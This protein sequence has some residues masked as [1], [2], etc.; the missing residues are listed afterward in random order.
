MGGIG[1]RSTIPRVNRLGWCERVL[2]PRPAPAPPPLPEGSS[3]STLS[4]YLDCVAGKLDYGTQAAKALAHI[5][6]NHPLRRPTT[7]AVTKPRCV[8]PGIIYLVTRRCSERRFFLRPD[9]AVTWVFEYLLGLLSKKYGIAIHAYVVMSNHYH[10]VVTDTEGRLPDFQRD[11]NSLLARAINALRGR[12]DSFW[13]GESYSG[14][15]LLED[16]DVIA[17]MG[18]TL[19]NPVEARLVNRARQWEG[20]TS[21]G[22]VFGRPRQVRRP[23]KFFS[24]EMPEVV[25]LEITRPGC[26]ERLSD[27]ELLAR[28]QADVAR[29]ELAHAQLGKA[30]GMDRVRKQQW[31]AS[32]ESF[33]A[34]RGLRPTIAGAN[35]WARIEA[36]QRSKEWQREY[37]AA[38][39]QFISGIRNVVFPTGTWWMCV[40]LRCRIAIE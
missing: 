21:A 33:E 3:V 5:P 19:A 36:L 13:E 10:L 16:G 17:K 11:L 18:Y 32:P 38:L 4:S 29:R 15:K 23:E 31:N 39:A 8:L 34:R 24:D 40:R 28:V 22:M 30:M 9:P 12:W 20:A 1:W 35:K 7:P 6:C 2:P 25:D 37:R 26:Y 27:E 14:V